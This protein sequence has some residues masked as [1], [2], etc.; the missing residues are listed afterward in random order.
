MSPIGKP[1]EDGNLVHGARHYAGK[2]LGPSGPWKCPSCQVQNEG[3]IEAGCVHC[4]S[5]SPAKSQA[6]NPAR[7]ID[8]PVRHQVTTPRLAT[9]AGTASVGNAEERRSLS[10][11][12]VTRILQY[13]CT[14]G[15]EAAMLH[16]LQRAL[17]GKYAFDWGTITAAIVDETSQRQEDILGLANRQP[18]VWLGGPL[19]PQ[20]GDFL[21]GYQPP[22]AEAPGREESLGAPPLVGRIHRPMPET[23]ATG[24]NFTQ[25]DV[26][27]ADLIVRSFG[28][29]VAHTLALALSSIAPELEGNSEPQKFLSSPECLRLANAL[30]QQIPDQWKGEPPAAQDEPPPEAPPPLAKQSVL[31]RI[32]EGSRP[33]AVPWR[34][35]TGS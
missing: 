13:V 11:L 26:E 10:P 24:P 18:G 19:T 7:V 31:D 25:D 21:T 30:M 28:L 16:G 33:T 17:V 27:A 8:V 23:P 35:P 32:R 4:G 14:P 15:K 5:G 12:V 6:G 2:T 1:T 29:R 9:P 34:D 22:F 3:A 20:T